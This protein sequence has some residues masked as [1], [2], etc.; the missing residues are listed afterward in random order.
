MGS[1]INIE[2]LVFVLDVIKD[3]FWVCIE[4]DFGNFYVYFFNDFV[5]S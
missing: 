5:N 3:G 2:F 4:C 1:N